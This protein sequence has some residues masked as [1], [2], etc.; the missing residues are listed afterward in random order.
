MWSCIY[1]LSRSKLPED[2]SY[3]IIDMGGGS[4]QF[5]YEVTSTQKAQYSGNNDVLD[6]AGRHLKSTYFSHRTLGPL[7]DNKEF[8]LYVYSNN[9]YGVNSA[10]GKMF[11]VSTDNT[12]GKSHCMIKKEAP[13]SATWNFKGTD[14]IGEAYAE[15]LNPVK[16]LDEA[17]NILTHNG[18]IGDANTSIDGAWRGPGLAENQE[19]VLTS[20]LY[21]ILKDAGFEQGEELNLAKVN[22]ARQRICKND[23]VRELD[24][25][26]KPFLCASVT[27]VYA[28]LAFGWKIEENR[29][30]RTYRKMNDV[31]VSWAFGVAVSA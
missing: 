10:R 11:G 13:V 19:I 5:A 25:D 24:A 27:Y 14:F 26:K 3:A 30:F 6:P 9:G 4:A 23:N 1:T 15:G 2:K 8:D 20:G 18:Q 7:M 22:A 29:V 28:A 17:K 12:R 31:T 16:C 21:W